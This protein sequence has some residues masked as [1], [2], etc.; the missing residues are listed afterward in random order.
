MIDPHPSPR[1][2][3]HLAWFLLL[4]EEYAVITI[5]LCSTP[6]SY[7]KEL[8]V[9]N[10]QLHHASRTLSVQAKRLT[11]IEALKAG[12][13]VINTQHDDDGEGAEVGS[14]GYL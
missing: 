11:E 1:S 2:I 3:P 10:Y 9:L 12:N 7:Y 14:L 13:D 4:L 6:L 5:P 8:N